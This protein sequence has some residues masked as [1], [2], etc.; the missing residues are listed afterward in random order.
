MRIREVIVEKQVQWVLS[1]I[2]RELADI[3][4]ENIIENLERRLLNYEVV[5]EF[6]TNLKEEF[7]EKNKEANKVT[8]LRRLE[9]G[10]KIMKE[11]VQE[12]KRVARK[13]GYKEQPLIKEFKYSINRTIW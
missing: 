3:Q 2:Q 13:S 4:K 9:Q 8:K 1:Y 6:Q 10:G 12:F 7:G 11:F 5:G